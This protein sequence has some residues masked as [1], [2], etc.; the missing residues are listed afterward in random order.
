MASRVLLFLVVTA[1]L[2]VTFGLSFSRWLMC[3]SAEAPPITPSP[4]PG[5]TTCFHSAIG[6]SPF[7][8]LYGYPPRLLAV[9]PSAVS[10]P[11]VTIWASDRQ[12]MDQLLQHHLNRAK[13]R[14]KKQSDQN[15]SERSF[16]VGDFVYLKVQLYVQT[17]LAP[18]SHLK[19]AFRFFGP[20]RILACVDSVA[21]K[22][23]LP[24]HSAI[25]PVFHVSQ[26]KKAVRAAHQVIPTL[27]SDFAIHL[28]PEQIL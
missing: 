9:D 13:H 3:H 28:A 20:F 14:M 17:S 5:D 15:K 25:H 27:P 11:E 18:R 10:H 6:R 22:L 1:Y 4:M 8:A 7:E 16:S 19:L 12:W 23:E 26:L 24:A 21:Y 2:P